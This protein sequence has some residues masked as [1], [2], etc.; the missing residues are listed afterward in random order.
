LAAARRAEFLAALTARLHRFILLANL[1]FHGHRLLA[2]C[3]L[4]NRADVE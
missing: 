2:V 3:T 4:I 1:A